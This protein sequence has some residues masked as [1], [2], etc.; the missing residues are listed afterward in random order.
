MITPF[1]HMLFLIRAYGVMKHNVAITDHRDVIALESIAEQL[2]ID[3]DVV[4][5]FQLNEPWVL[6]NSIRDQLIL[7][8]HELHSYMEGVDTVV[9]SEFEEILTSFSYNEMADYCPDHTFDHAS[10]L[11]RLTPHDLSDE[12]FDSGMLPNHLANY[13]VDLDSLEA[14][15]KKEYEKDLDLAYR[16]TREMM[17]IFAIFEHVHTQG[18][19]LYIGKTKDEIYYAKFA[20]EAKAAE[21][22]VEESA[23]LVT[24][25][26]QLSAEQRNQIEASFRELGVEGV[27]SLM[28]HIG[29]QHSLYLMGFAGQEGFQEEMKRSAGKAAEMLI[30]GMKALKARFDERKR[31][32]SKEAEGIKEAIDKAIESLKDKAGEVDGTHVDQLKNQLTKA[33]YSEQAGK[34]SGVKTFTQ[35]S[36]ALSTISDEFTS[37]IKDMKEAESKLKEAESKVSE[38]S[39]APAGAT[40]SADET[41]KAQMKAQ[42]AEASKE[43]KDLM[44]SASEAIGQAMKGLAMLRSIKATLD[45]VVKSAETKVDGQESWML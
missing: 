22:I 17:F 21:T 26:E 44:K 39:K 45:R 25:P 42:M 5:S 16:C 19:E 4:A 9:P 28:H 37:Q 31:E 38:A 23:T 13:Q 32:G 27:E 43:A 7:Q 20:K 3:K 40:D 30:A 14:E 34:L 11:R 15:L 10:F 12:L 33:G 29:N 41:A 1:K 36:Q 8:L 6:L 18:V 2:K 24:G 35:L